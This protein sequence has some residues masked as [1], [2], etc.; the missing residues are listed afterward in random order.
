MNQLIGF[1][2]DGDGALKIV[3][4]I[5]GSIN[6]TPA[7]DN[8][9]PPPPSVQLAS[10]EKELMEQVAD[11]R[12]RKRIS[13]AGM[14]S[15]DDLLDPLEEQYIE[16]GHQF[17]GDDDIVA[18]VRHE[19]AVA[20]G[21]VIEIDS[22]SDA[23]GEGEGEELTPEM[24]TTE[25]LK[26]CQTLEKVCLTKGDPTQSMELSRTL[27]L[28]RGHVQREEQLNARQMTLEESWGVKKN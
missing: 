4:N 6:S 14:P 17:S 12:A 23:E 1:E 15:I 3:S 11:L 10:L 18:Y 20:R 9:S 7:A 16:E 22:D 19:E 21:D 24:G 26:L 25:V 2:G 27:R 13:A 28:F 8:V 5:R